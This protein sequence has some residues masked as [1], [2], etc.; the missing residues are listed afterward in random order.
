[1]STPPLR[2]LYLPAAPAR[3]AD[4]VLIL[5]PGAYDTPEHFIEHGLVDELRASGLP[6]DLV[7]AE[8]DLSLV[9]DGGLVRRLHADVVAPLR[10]AGYRRIWLGGIS[11]GGLTAMTHADAFPGAVE[12]LCLFAPYPGNRTITAEIAA[13]G[14]LA[15]WPAD[16]LPD[17]EGERRG[18]RALR[19]LA[20]ETPARVWLGY[21][22]DDR[23]APGH[24]LMA[25]VLP[26]GQVAVRPGGHDW[27]TW[28]VLFRELLARGTLA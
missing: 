28:R 9:S 23:F 7:L 25:E 3:R 4:S 15:A 11:L 26:A 24:R 2:S 10:A 17:D 14:G 1:M 12:G 20:G 16:E 6:L 13:A 5:L 8:T 27:P 22:V 18:W 19:R 21:G